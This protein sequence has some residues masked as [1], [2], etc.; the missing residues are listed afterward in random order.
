MFERLIFN[1]LYQFLDEHNLLSIH[2]SGFRYN[3][4][5]IVRTLYKAFDAYPALDTRGIFLDMFK[6]FD[7]VWHKELIEIKGSFR[8]ITKAYSELFNK[9]I[10]KSL[11]QW[12]DFRMVACKT[13]CA[14]RVY[15][16]STLFSNIFLISQ[17][18]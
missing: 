13:R 3:D 8:F 7:K 2:Q 5:C 17:R 18:T 12:S 9:Q 10:S 16:R 1:S 15:S 6:A 14:T 4:S 11:T